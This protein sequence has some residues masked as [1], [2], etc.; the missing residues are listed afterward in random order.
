MISTGQSFTWT[1]DQGLGSTAV[2]A[3]QQGLGLDISVEESHRAAHL[4]QPEPDAQEV[5]LVAHEQGHTVPFLQFDFLQENIGEPVAPLLDVP[6][7]VDASVVDDKRLV[8]DAL[9]L[10]DEAIQDRAHA[11]C[12]LEEL[13]FHSVPNHPHQKEEV[14]PEVWEAKFLQNMSGENA[15]GQSREPSQRQSHVCGR[16]ALRDTEETPGEE[17]TAHCTH[18]HMVQ[19]INTD[20][21]T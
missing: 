17:R 14:S 18:D 13:Q 10:L 3:V 9:R 6:V 5:G 20:T 4:G 2:E 1:S 15:R 12:E 7:G 21:V 8:G 19:V 11:G 16:E